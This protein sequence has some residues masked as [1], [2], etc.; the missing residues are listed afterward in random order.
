MRPQFSTTPI[1]LLIGVLAS[2]LIKSHADDPGRV[3][4]HTSNAGLTVR[5]ATGDLLRGGVVFLYKYRRDEVMAEKGDYYPTDPTYWDEMKA[6]GL[7]AVRVVCFDPWQRS[8]GDRGTTQPY[9]SANWERRS[10]GE[11][12]LDELSQIVDL[13][14]EREMYVMI[15]YHDAG[16]YRDPDYRTPADKDRH[17]QYLSLIHI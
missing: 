17:F 8:H 15:N 3:I 14:A 12:L 1:L 4:V 7:N 11:V 6:A 13:A 10:E 5:A 2:P 9:P 16:G